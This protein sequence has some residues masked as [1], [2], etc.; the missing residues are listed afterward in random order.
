MIGAYFSKPD[1]HCE[2]YWWPKYATADRNNNYDIRRYPWRWTQYKE[3]THS[4]LRELM[5]NYGTVD[6]LWLDG[7]WV[8]PRETV[9]AEVLSWGARIPEWSQD[10]DMAAVATMARKAQPGLLIVDRTVHGLYENYRTPEQRIPNAKL[11]YPWES[12]MTLANNWGYVPGDKYKSS[13]DVI[14]SLI[15][16][17]AKGGNLL[18]GIGPRPDGTLT[19]E[20]LQRLKEIGTWIHKNGAAIYNTRTVNNYRD[21]SVYF[22][23]NTKLGLYYALACIKENESVPAQLQ[24]KNNAPKQGT[25]M[26]LLQTGETVKWEQKGDI[27]TVQLPASFIQKNKMIPAVALSFTPATQ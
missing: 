15:E 4:Q 10:I 22:T 17:V 14:H 19:Q 2:Y 24:W 25:K 9:N 20:A 12:C 18:L 21:S 7:G 3:F 1:W 11:D 8:R 13:A 5:Q 23:R 26:V 16:I 6:I 27:T